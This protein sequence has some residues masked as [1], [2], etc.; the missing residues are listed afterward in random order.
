MREVQRARVGIISLKF[1]LKAARARERSHRRRR[2]AALARRERAGCGRGPVGAREPSLANARLARVPRVQRLR[3]ARLQQDA[4][5]RRRGSILRSSVAPSFAAVLQRTS[6]LR[7]IHDV[8]SGDQALRPD[9]GVVEAPQHVRARERVRQRATRRRRHARRRRGANRRRRGYERGG[10]FCGSGGRGVAGD[11]VRQQR[12]PARFGSRRERPERPRGDQH[13]LGCVFVVVGHRVDQRAD[14]FRKKRR[15]RALFPGVRERRAQQ[16]RTRV[17]FRG[18]PLARL[19]DRQR[20]QRRKLRRDQP[21]GRG[22][23]RRD[24]ERVRQKRARRVVRERLLVFVVSIRVHVRGAVVRRARGLHQPRRVRRVGVRFVRHAREQHRQ[25]A[26]RER[27]RA[28]RRRRDGVRLRVPHGDVEP[29]ARVATR[30]RRV[31]HVRRSIRDHPSR[32]RLVQRETHA[33]RSV[34]AHRLQPGRDELFHVRDGQKRHQARD[35]AQARQTRLR[36]S[37]SGVRQNRRAQSARVFFQRVCGVY[38]YVTLAAFVV[39]FRESLHERLDGSVRRLFDVVERVA[40]RARDD[41]RHLIRERRQ[42]VRVF[43]TRADFADERRARQPDL[44]ARLL[45]RPG[46][47]RAC[48]RRYERLEYRFQRPGAPR[49][50]LRDERE[51]RLAN[52]LRRIGRAARHR[53]D[54]ARRERD[55]RRV[56][57]GRPRGVAGEEPVRSRRSPRVIRGLLAEMTSA[58][59]SARRRVGGGGGH[60]ASRE[61]RASRVEKSNENGAIVRPS[62]MT[63]RLVSASKARLRVDRSA[64][65]MPFRSRWMLARN[66]AASVASPIARVRPARDPNLPN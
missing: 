49:D 39:S 56:R 32:E 16:T 14:D 9:R 59:V 7:D 20:E 61:R 5:Q 48:E 11:E 13:A 57:G 62:G 40:R 47:H 27:E 15:R 53:G 37:V 6:S 28:R 42:D 10:A 22:A 52:L 12:D 3:R 18:G 36:V 35:R 21:T 2:R 46:A 19:A 45:L 65:E 17:A 8:R 4:E 44:L 43:R 50:V 55:E 33:R 51:T 30:A 58:E 24:V 29:V 26:R 64:S 54:D 41:V 66:A 63:Y 38:V 31:I 25:Q 23:R 1:A 34:R 60:R